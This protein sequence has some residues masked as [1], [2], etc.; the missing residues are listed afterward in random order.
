MT[1]KIELWINGEIVSVDV[2]DD[3]T[4][5]DTLRERL[6]DTSTR[7]ACGIGV[8]GACTVLLDGDAVSACLQLSRTVVGRDV[9]TAEYVLTK[10]DS[11]GRK[12]LDAFV[13]SSAFQCSYCIPAFALTVTHL[14]TR[15]PDSSEGEIREALGGNLCRCG[16]YPQIMQAVGQ[17]VARRARR[18]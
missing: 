7:Y 3:E 13:A 18:I 1:V 6:D 8:C 11:L 14:L 5:L 16:S 9:E 10:E 15:D 4:L 2:E 17:L 12:V